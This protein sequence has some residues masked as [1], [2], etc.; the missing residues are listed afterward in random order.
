M[1]RYKEREPIPFYFL[2]DTFNAEEIKIQLDFMRDTGV[3]AFFL[4]V[5]DG[6]LDEAYGTET[7][8][9]RVK[10]IVEQ[11][12]ERKIK[13][14]LY[15]EDSFPSG[16][17]GGQIAIEHPELQA[18]SLKVV[19]LKAE[20]I[21]DGTA[22]RVLG[23]VRGLFGYAVKN[24]NG[25][26]TSRKITDCFGVVRRYW[27]RRDMNKTY[28][29]D[30]QDKLFFPHVRAGTCYSEIIFEAEAGDGEEIYVAYLEPV[31][32]DGHYGLQADCLN[33]RTTEEFIARTHEKY[34]KYVGEYFG[35]TIPGIFMDEPSAG[36]L[37]PYT[38]EVV[39]KFKEIRGYDVT[40]YYYKLSSEYY[41]DGKKVRR[42]Y[43]E[44][45]TRLFCDNFISPI[46]QWCERHGLEST[47][48][49]Y[50]E[51]DPL[52]GS[53]CAQSVYRQ[54]KLMGIPGFDIIGRYVGDR[55]HCALILGAKIV[56]SAAIQ[57]GKKRILAECFA[58]NPF[59]YGYDGL[60]KTADW[61]FACGIDTFAPHAFHYGYGAY[62]RTDAGK[63]FFYQDP[64]YGEYTEFAAY[65]GRISN[66]LSRFNHENEV[67][68]V[69][70]SCGFAEEVPFPMC[71][72]G[73]YPSDR[74]KTMQSRLYAAVRYL[75]ERQIVWN[76]ADVQGVADADVRD[77][78]VNIGECSYKKVIFINGGDEEARVYE[79]T[80]KAGVDCMAFDGN[81][82]DGFPQKE[83]LFGGE[84]I[85]ALEKRRGSEKL[86]FLYQNDK[87]FAEV[88][89]PVVGRTVVY[90][91][92]ND[93]WREVVAKNGEAT[94]GIKGYGSVVLL[95]GASD[96]IKTS[97]EYTY[98]VTGDT[99]LECERNPQ[100]VY[101]PVGAKSAI[102]TY[103]IE[104]GDGKEKITFEAHKYA[105]LRELIGTQDEIYSG[106]YVVPYFDVAPRMKS[107]YPKKAVFRAKIEKIDGD[108]AVLFD[109]GTFSGDYKLFWNG[110]EIPAGAIVPHRVYDAKN[111]I[112]KPVWKDGINILEISFDEGGEFDGVNGEIYLY[113]EQI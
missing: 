63:S 110:E 53:L 76:V 45:I 22:K 71:N 1:K 44:T 34:A 84:N 42:D 19:K 94:I 68:L 108:E 104:I 70:P 16:N 60:R 14:W 95:T 105:R 67:L 43:I 37:L 52:S 102:T 40:D 99:V 41:G 100:W 46:T 5:R 21:K 8:F 9:K 26:E 50:G 54:I 25:V 113:K 58:L 82:F 86:L 11:A 6:I 88:K 10:F 51:E 80:L 96:E 66:L 18:Y 30:M 56:V 20:E 7:Y 38:D 27:Y 73:V 55:E 87:S 61:L 59:N 69:L 39:A 4:H 85:L 33:R 31:R 77:G 47:G 93:E 12:A 101:M 83:G 103:D 35:T 98:E 89:V 92:K 23:R 109:G 24:E 32:T 17:A 90:D 91:G 72:T 15:D 48:H 62:Q 107:I 29:C 36:G 79:K 64:L 3:G 81:S 28:Y 74:A 106:E 57:S 97:G 111:K 65:A 49:F 75:I 13:V 2:N 78:A 112:F